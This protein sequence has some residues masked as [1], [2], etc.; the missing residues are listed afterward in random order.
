M[1]KDSGKAFHVILMHIN[2]NYKLI[3]K[4]FKLVHTFNLEVS[5]AFPYERH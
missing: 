2:F 3:L 4:Y 5:I 1:N